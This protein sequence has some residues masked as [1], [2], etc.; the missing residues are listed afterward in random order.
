MTTLTPGKV[1]RSREP[2]LTVENDLAAGRHR[3]QLTVVDDGGLES[4]P[5][6]LV[7]AVLDR[8]TT[9]PPT[10]SPPVSPPI[11]RIPIDRI[12]PVV[13]TPVRPSPPPPPPII[14]P[15]IRPIRPIR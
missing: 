14:G 9:S 10:T 5:A 13:V 1:F 7:V 11:G 8:R 6:E 3:F 4:E 12:D 2:T 15:V